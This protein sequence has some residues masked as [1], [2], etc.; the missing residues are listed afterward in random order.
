M[1]D[2]DALDLVVIIHL[3]EKDTLSN[4]SIEDRWC[5]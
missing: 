5:H 4:I 3:F 2:T 1:I